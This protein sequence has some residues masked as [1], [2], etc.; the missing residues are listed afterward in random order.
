MVDVATFE[1]V[2]AKLGPRKR[3]T[4][5]RLETRERQ[6]RA[7]YPL[8]PTCAHC[9]CEYAGGRLAAKQGAARQYTHA[10]PK[11]RAHPEAYQ[12]KV[13][14]QCRVW[15]F[16]AAELETAIRDLIVAQRSNPDFESDVRE[17]ILERDEFRQRAGEA[18]ERARLTL[19]QREGAYKR[20]V[21]V[22]AA[23]VDDDATEAAG[24]VGDEA[25]IEQLR[26]A[27]AA[28]KTARAALEG[29]ERFAASRE[30]AWSRLAAI[31]HETR[32]LAAAWDKLGL[33]DRKVLLDYWILDVL[34]VVEP[35]AGMRRANRKTALVTLRTAPNAPVYFE[36]GGGQAPSEESAARISAST[37]GSNSSGARARRAAVAAGEP[38]LPS[39]HAACARTSGSSSESAAAS[40]G[41]SSG[42]PML[43]ST[44]AALRRKPRSL[45]LFIGEPLNAAENSGCGMASSSSA[46]VLASLPASA[47]RGA[48]GEPSASSRANLR[49]NGQTSWHTSHPYTRSPIP[50][51]SVSGIAPRCS[52][53][54]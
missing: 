36:L 19:A 2:A 1:L 40:A 11:Q 16:D 13:A 33:E 24:G 39:A 25:M 22:A 6:A 50:S 32:H 37:P 21:R 53:V 45:A 23:L 3:R 15:T 29:A 18:L 35:V 49:E 10:N 51:R 12:R 30:D 14:A 54:R 48:N 7:L 44:T 17:L 41:T 5:G 38:T 34:V 28:V 46:S 43:P 20:L 27:R 47:G 26:V 42:D 8:A 52:I 31:I 9:G 4:D